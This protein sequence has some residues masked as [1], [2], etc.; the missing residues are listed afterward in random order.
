MNKR[1]RSYCTNV[2]TNNFS[3]TSQQ[4]EKNCK[5]LSN[6]YDKDFE[7]RRNVNDAFSFYHSRHDNSEINEESL[8]SK[9]NEIDSE[10]SITD[11]PMENNTEN[12]SKLMKLNLPNKNDDRFIIKV[13]HGGFCRI[14]T[15]RRW[16]GFDYFRSQL[17]TQGKQAYKGPCSWF[18]HQN[19][20]ISLIDENDL[21]SMLDFL[22]L[23]G[24]RYIKVFLNNPSKQQSNLTNDINM[25]K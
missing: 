4:Q 8:M 12:F 11:I 21:N 24:E 17:Y 9:C 22:E 19:D 15:Y 10:Q 13:S 18:D 1:P 23:H 20:R 14:F 6:K 5:N 2:P 3:F 25:S 7:N 16:D